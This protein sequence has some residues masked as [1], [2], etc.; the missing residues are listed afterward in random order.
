MFCMPLLVCFWLLLPSQIQCFYLSTLYDLL[1]YIVLWSLISTSHVIMTCPTPLFV[2]QI[3]LLDLLEIQDGRSFNY[4]P[5]LGHYRETADRK[6]RHFNSGTFFK[7]PPLWF[8]FPLASLRSA[9]RDRWPNIF[10]LLSLP[11]LAERLPNI[12]HLLS[13]PVSGS[14]SEWCPCAI[15]RILSAIIIRLSSFPLSAILLISSVKISCFS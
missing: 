14:S 11:V 12:F 3:Q 8:F 15:V 5:I 6:I 1:V 4:I 2:P 10:H 7:P 13:L 9:C